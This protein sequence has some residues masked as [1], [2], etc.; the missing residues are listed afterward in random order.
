M[1]LLA[2]VIIRDKTEKHLEKN[3]QEQTKKTVT[4][5]ENGVTSEEN[6]NV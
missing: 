1:L 4:S 3:K 6:C 2:D 5:K